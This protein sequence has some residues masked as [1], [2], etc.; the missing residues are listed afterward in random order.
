MEEH[1]I[2]I[3]VVDT[4]KCNPK[5]CQKEC[6]RFCPRARAG[7]ETVVVDDKRAYIDEKTCVGCGICVKKCPRKAIK[8]VNLISEPKNK[9]HQYGKNGFRLYRLPIPKESAVVGVLGLN[10]TGKTTAIRILAGILKPNLGKLDEDVGWEE[11]LE[12][13]RGSELQ[14]YLKRLAEGEIRAV[15]KPQEVNKLPVYYGEKHVNSLI[16]ADAPDFELV[17]SYLNISKLLERKLSELS[18]GELQRVAIAACML[19][20][21]DFYLF[22]EPSSFLDVEQRLKAA[23]AIRHLASA[24]KSVVVIEHDLATLDFLSDYIHIFYG[25]P[26]VYGVVSASY[27]V[28]R[29]INLYLDGYIKE[30]NIRF[31]DEPLSFESQARIEEE[32]DVVVKYTRL[33][34]K[35]PSFTLEVDEGELESRNIIAVLGANALGKTTFA[36]MLAGIIKPDE[37]GISTNIT[38]SYKPQYVQL[39]KNEESMTVMEALTKASGGKNIMSAAIKEKILKPLEID[40]LLERKLSELSGGELQRVAIAAC[41]LR[42]ADFYLFD[43]PSSFLDVE[44]RVRFAK[45][46]KR[47]VMDTQKGCLVIDHDLLL[48]TYL[49]KKCILFEGKPSVNGKASKPL[50][51]EEGINLFLKGVGITFR[52]DDETFRPRANKPGSQKDREQKEKGIYYL[53]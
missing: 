42:D 39:G 2:R 49:A 28:K 11:I 35:F 36:K 40:E 19:R 37:G 43:E 51:F 3:A 50:S 38:I 10:G 16:N 53:G 23:Q 30:E 45:L 46:L 44:Q 26:A 7:D 22:D 48:L 12:R 41:M 6:L 13:F 15:L 32:G 14:T 4:S 24:G 5:K 21:A 27:T 25:E 1:K 17:D 33:M 8:I 9:V 18:G 29:G 20:D 34:K 52:K 31:R 47:F